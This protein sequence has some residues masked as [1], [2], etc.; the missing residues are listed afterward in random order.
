MLIFLLFVLLFV[1]LCFYPERI[2]RYYTFKPSAL[3]GQ[4]AACAAASS[5]K[6]ERAAMLNCQFSE[7]RDKRQVTTR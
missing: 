4:R 6:N 2:G 1:C 5:P 7:R 3:I